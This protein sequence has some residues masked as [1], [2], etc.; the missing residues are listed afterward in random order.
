MK[1]SNL[2]VV[3]NLIKIIQT[4]SN[5]IQTLRACHKL[6]GS[7]NN[8][9]DGQIKIITSTSDAVGSKVRDRWIEVLTERR[10]LR[11][12]ELKDKYNVEYDGD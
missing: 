9:M 1:S 4:Y 6:I 2:I 7:Q 10:Q 12:N 5:E 3:E 11:I 8:H